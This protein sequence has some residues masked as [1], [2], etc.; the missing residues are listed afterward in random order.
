M[1]RGPAPAARIDSHKVSAGGA[2]VTNHPGGR[3]ITS[4]GCVQRI[5]NQL[6]RPS[7]TH[8]ATRDS[9]AGAPWAW[10]HRASSSMMGSSPLPWGMIDQVAGLCDEMGPPSISGMDRQRSCRM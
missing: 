6:L 3:N 4:V 10:Q 2:E 5:T 8:V 7:H 9:A 1:T